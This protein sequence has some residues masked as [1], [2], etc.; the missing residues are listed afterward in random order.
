[1]LELAEKRMLDWWSVP[2][3]SVVIC[4]HDPGRRALLLDALESLRRQSRPPHEVILVVDHNPGLI[5]WIRARASDVTLVANVGEPGL[6]CARNTGIRAASGDVIAFLDDD[7]VAS[8]DWIDRLSAAYED[9]GTAAAG[10]AV[11]AIWERQPPWFPDEFGWVVGCSYRGL[12]S[13]PARVRNLIGCNMS[14]RTNVFADV[15]G[16]EGGLGRIAGRPFGCEET[17]LCIRIGKRADEAVLYDPGAVVRHHVPAERATWRYF[18]L[19]CYCEGISKAEVS[20][21]AG[22][23]SGLASERRYVLRT[24]PAGVWRQMRAARPS[25]AVAIVAGFLATLA[26]FVI[27]SA[28]RAPASAAGPEAVS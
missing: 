1:M 24:L 15:G 3:V 18:L 8:S 2:T 19:R 25:R 14:F 10:G 26:G 4:T 11:L 6:A 22:R 12:P 20:R 13:G 5:E 9:P 16:F 28:T 27:G 23:Q 7:A 17:E 21:I